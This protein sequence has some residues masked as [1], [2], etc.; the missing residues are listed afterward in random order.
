MK[1]IG[2][3]AV[4]TIGAYLSGTLGLARAI[5][6]GFMSALMM[7]SW[8]FVVAATGLCIAPLP[9]GFKVLTEKLTPSLRTFP[10]RFLLMIAWAPFFTF[11]GSLG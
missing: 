2:F 9:L 1:I 4:L 10:I 5:A 8:T 7:G 3:R 6:L 11:F